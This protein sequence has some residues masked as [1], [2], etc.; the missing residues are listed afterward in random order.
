MFYCSEALPPTSHPFL[1]FIMLKERATALL[2]GGGGHFPYSGEAMF[3]QKSFAGFTDTTLFLRWSSG[4]LS[5]RD[6]SWSDALKRWTRGAHGVIPSHHFPWK[7]EK[8][9]EINLFLL[10]AVMHAGIIW[11]FMIAW[12]RKKM[13]TFNKSG[14]FSHILWWIDWLDICDSREDTAVLPTRCDTQVFSAPA[15]IQSK[16]WLWIQLVRPFV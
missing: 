15:H 16:L 4:I 1:E 9:R 8:Q 7:I 14:G 12:G 5:R 10:R 3:W 11:P 13:C 6:A 2:S